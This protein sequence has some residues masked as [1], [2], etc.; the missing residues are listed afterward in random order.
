MI[1]IEEK[2]YNSMQF[3]FEDTLDFLTGKRC[4]LRGKDVYVCLC[5]YK[6]CRHSL[7]PVLIPYVYCQ[8]RLEVDIEILDYIEIEILFETIVFVPGKLL[9]GKAT[10][11]QQENLAFLQTRTTYE[12][13]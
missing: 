7:W 12:H 2:K 10:N 13:S 3:R 11:C 8:N 5:L 9:P 4:F 6:Q 1:H